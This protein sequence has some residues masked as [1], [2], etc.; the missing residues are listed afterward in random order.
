MPKKNQPVGIGMTPS[1]TAFG[2]FIRERRI[3]LGLSQMRVAKILQMS[4]SD[5]SNF[6]V[7]NCYPWP[8][9]LAG[10]AQVL[11]LELSQLESLI[12]QRQP[13]Q[14]KT[15][16]G[17]F[18]KNRREQLGLSMEDFA[19]KL[20]VNINRAK[21][22]EIGNNDGISYDFLNQL[23]EALELELSALS[24]FVGTRAKRTNGG[25]GEL[26]RARRKE[27]GLSITQLGKK[28]Q[29]TRQLI[30]Q[31][32]LGHSKLSRSRVFVERLAEVLNLEVTM[33]QIAQ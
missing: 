17:F 21:N 13:T 16:F 33:L 29:R 18:I 15:N 14:P 11:N 5:Y 4:Q 1:K 9:R 27:L 22:L 24:Q 12:P 26:I 28:L 10:M 32:E 7:G 25:L 2:K 20:K 19:K 3:E 23:A 8:K 30:S 6:E 31:I